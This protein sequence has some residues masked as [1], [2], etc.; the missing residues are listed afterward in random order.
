MTMPI[1]LFAGPRRSHGRLA[2]CGVTLIELMVSMVIGLFIVLALLTLL[3][4]VNR[5]NSELTKTNRLIE[6]GRFSLQL[7]QADVSH[8]GFWGGFVPQFEDLTVYGIPTDVPTAVPDP[9][10]D[11]ASWNEVHKANLIG[12]PVQA[13]EIPAVVPNPTLPVCATRVVSPQ[14]RT[15]VLVVRHVEPCKAGVDSGCVAPAAADIYFQMAHCA[16]TSSPNYTTTTYA[17]GTPAQNAA[18]PLFKRDCLTAADAY[19]YVSD[20]YYIRDYAVTAGDGLPTLVRSTFAAGTHQAP[21]ALIEGIQGFRVEIGLDAIS[22]SGAAVNYGAPIAWANPA[23][24]VSPTNRGDGAPE[25]F[26][27]CTATSP[28]TAEQL[29]NAVAVKLHVLVRSDTKTPGYTDSKVYCLGSSCPAAVSPSCPAGA[30]NPAPLLGPY[31]DGYKRHLF[32]Q[33]VR[34]V[35]VSSRRE[36]PP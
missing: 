8:G 23:H 9:C 11:L 34:L 18:T 15:D 14:P 32:T 5:N 31:C 7:L 1:S 25:S 22:D 16:N 29:G 19:K 21:Q 26:V 13:Y 24:L 10:L 2:Q 4:N 35:N 33:T 17:L 6:N 27:R 12:I 28:C 3:I 30:A 36:T 20:M